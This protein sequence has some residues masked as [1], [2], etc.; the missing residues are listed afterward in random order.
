MKDVLNLIESTEYR[1]WLAEHE[2]ILAPRKYIQIVLASRLDIRE[3]LKAL[4]KMKSFVAENGKLSDIYKNRCDYLE[5]GIELL[6]E[7]SENA[8]FLLTEKARC[9]Q[10]HCDYTF[11]STLP[12]RAFREIL[13]HIAKY[14]TQKYSEYEDSWYVI[15][16]YSLSGNTYELDASY[17]MSDKGTVWNVIYPHEHNILF[18]KLDLPMPYKEGDILTIDCRPFHELHHAVV[19]C[20]IDINNTSYSSYCIHYCDDGMEL[21]S[22]NH[23][24]NDL[25]EFSP[26]LR[27]EKFTGKL[28]ESEKIL[29]KVSRYIKTNEN[30]SKTIDM[31]DNIS[32]NYKD[33]EEKLI[34]LLNSENI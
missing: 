23:F 16:R 3:K 17:T 27:L 32:N 8:L 13:D 10:E 19:V 15:E 4:R 18:S 28:T 24:F 14:D 20:N 6:L 9:T 25:G 22:I 33:F 12:F 26:L 29:E 5:R 2:N 21:C 7:E 1:Q 30:G 34:K 11:D 31:L